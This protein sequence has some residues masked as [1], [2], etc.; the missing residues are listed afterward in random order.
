MIII[1]NNWPMMINSFKHIAAQIPQTKQIKHWS[2][3]TTLAELRLFKFTSYVFQ[4][5]VL[6]IIVHSSIIMQNV[7]FSILFGCD[8]LWEYKGFISGNIRTVC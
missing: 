5:F 1:G 8:L 2:E 7:Y 3:Y 6:D 4:N